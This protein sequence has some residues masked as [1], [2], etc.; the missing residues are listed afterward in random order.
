MTLYEFNLLEE[1]DKLTEL[2][3]QD[4]IA[5]KN[6]LEYKYELYQ[7]EDFYIEVKTHETIQE[8]NVSTFRTTKLL[9]PYLEA[10]PLPD[11]VQRLD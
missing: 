10:I 1:K 6:E 8:K 11:F 3:K 9:E 7:I 4:K 2:A 5:E